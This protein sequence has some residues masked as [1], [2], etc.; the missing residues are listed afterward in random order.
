MSKTV[1][2]PWRSVPA[3]A[4]TPPCCARVL[5]PSLSRASTSSRTSW[6]LR[7]S[8][9]KPWDV[10]RP[11]QSP[12]ASTATPPRA[13][14]D[15]IIATCAVRRIPDAWLDQIRP[16]GVIV[17]DLSPERE[18]GITRIEALA[19]GSARGR[20][21]P[22]PAGFIKMKG[23]EPVIPSMDTLVSRFVYGEGSQ[24]TAS[25]PTGI[26]DESFWF[27]A[28]LHLPHV[29]LLERRDVT[30][31]KPPASW[32]PGTCPGAALPDLKTAQYVP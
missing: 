30:L 8:V 21:L 31:M 12:T 4:T 27:L 14:Y 17:V 9:L 16:G 18:G 15:R 6:R 11:S 29:M 32:I 10:G 3:Q 2:R 23:A 24:R 22:N 7:E 5:A 26:R 28:R 20:F 25:V 1:S 13:P 19:D